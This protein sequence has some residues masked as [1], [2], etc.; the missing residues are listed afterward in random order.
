M[1][2]NVLVHG[3]RSRAAKKR[4]LASGG[5]L[6][7]K[8][9]IVQNRAQQRWVRMESRA[10]SRHL[11][12]VRDVRGPPAKATRSSPSSAAVLWRMQSQCAG[13][14]CTAV[15]WGCSQAGIYQKGGWDGGLRGDYPPPPPT[16][17]GRFNTSLQPGFDKHIRHLPGKTYCNT[18]PSHKTKNRTA[19]RDLGNRIGAPLFLCN[20]DQSHMPQSHN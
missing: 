10:G 17:Y 18:V 9:V 6:L 11:R 20:L 4:L 5:W 2:R 7:P 19:V 12:R 1:F 16:V 3:K 15:N 13:A 8:A 14:P